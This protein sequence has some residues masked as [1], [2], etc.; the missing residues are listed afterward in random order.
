MAD[1]IKKI[2]NEL[3][4]L[5][6]Q[7]SDIANELSNSF[8]N[9][10]TSARNKAEDLTKAF[11]K[12]ENISKQLSNEMR[13][14]KSSIDSSYN[15]ESKLNEELA[16]QL[17]INKKNS[18]EKAANIRKQINQIQN[19]RNLNIEL[20]YQYRKLENISEERKKQLSVSKVL[21]NTLEKN[22]GITKEEL[23]SFITL[24]GILALFVNTLFKADQQTTELAKSFG[25]SYKLASKIR[26]EFV[27]YSRTSIDAF[28]NTDRLF[29]AQQGLTEQLGI[30]VDFGNKERE[31]FAR[32]T[33]ITG[34][35]ADEAG[36]LAK[37]SSATGTT[38]KKYVSDLRV[39][40]NEAMRANKIHI[41]DKEL[42]SSISKL[43]AGILVKFQGNPKAL[44]ESVVQAKKLGISLEQIDKIGDS[45][46][47]W[48]SSIE[49]E[50]KAELITG[51]QLNF[52]RAR[53]AALTG[54]QA[55]LMQEMANQAGSLADYQK[56]NIIAQNSLAQAF[57]MSR[58]EMADMLMKQEMINKYGDAA[59][60]LNADQL[61]DMK[62]RNMNAAEYLNMVQNQ[63]SIQ[64]KF[65]DAME[66]LKDIIGNIAAGPL[67]S[68][69]KAFASILS[70]TDS[71]AVLLGGALLI[72][73]LRWVKMMKEAKKIQEGA[74][75]IS[76]IK[77]A[78]ESMGGLPVVG[79]ALATAAAAGGLAWYHSQQ[80]EDGI[81]PPGKG[82]FTITD[83]YGATAVTAAGDGIAV[84]PNISRGGNDMSPMIA[85]INEVRNAV[86]NLAAKSNDIILD[87]QKVGKQLGATKALGTSQIQNSYKLA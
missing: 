9:S 15:L 6:K 33:E 81:A 21:G 48:E 87:G 68:I 76:I 83:S 45:M 79:I 46:L 24:G 20:E 42:L 38:T 50:L 11:S 35:T 14:L 37:F 55:T 70:Y 17:A 5:E 47:E 67:G 36:R 2:Q 78:F 85:A 59:A 71:L 62:E 31:T 28:I 27:A 8:I 53:A 51:R 23:K 4:D 73:M 75:M 84:S 74:T 10:F 39:A 69:V 61:K 1:D 66:K 19:E 40:A 72:N 82:P 29:K 80:V 49:N 25:T 3:G 63:R 26:Q 22:L 65:N 32:L 16:K 7:V 43:S 41:S 30:A 64:E 56:M 60:K 13:K 77:A 52:E 18:L 58:D 44:A 12:G 86:N 57:G 54:D 34:L